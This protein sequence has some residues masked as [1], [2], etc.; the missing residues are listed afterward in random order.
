MPLHPF[1]VHLPMAI[2][3]L[4]P[5]PEIFLWWRPR[6]AR[7]ARTGQVFVLPVA[8]LFTI[9]ITLILH[10]GGEVPEAARETFNRHQDLA[11]FLSLA[12]TGYVWFLVWGFRRGEFH[13]TGMSRMATTLLSFS[14]SL[15]ATLTGNLGG[16]LVHEFGLA[17]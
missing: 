14:V 10:P 2:W 15:L 6:Q 13:L 12:S 1:L 8:W 4:A 5:L 17:L 16:R 7:L 3:V 11:L 9:V